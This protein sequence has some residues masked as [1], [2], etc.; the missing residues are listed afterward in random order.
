GRAVAETALAL[1]PP[2]GEVLCVCGA[3]NNAGDGLVAARHLHLAGVPVRAALAAE[4]AS[5]RGDAAASWKRAQRAGVRLEGTRWRA[6][7]RGVIVDALFGTGLARPLER[8]M[9]AQV[10]R[11]DAARSESGG[12]VR[13]L[14]V[15]LPSGLSAD[16]GA[17]LGAAVR[18]DATLAIAL[19]KLGLCLEPGRTLAGRIR[20]ARIGIADEAPGVAPDAQLWTRAAAGARRPPRPPPGPKGGLGPPPA[21]PAPPAQPPPPPP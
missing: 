10:R 12:A 13:V 19:P 9:A 17:V 20:V 4:G 21:A 16:T 11:I 18:A 1:L 3:G 8:A 5:L 2:G 7:A 14:A 15:D 6:P